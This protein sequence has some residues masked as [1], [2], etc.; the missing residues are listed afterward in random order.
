MLQL[1]DPKVYYNYTTAT[2][3]LALA[4]AMASV[5]V[6][7]PSCTGITWKNLILDNRDKSWAL[8]ILMWLQTQNL[9]AQ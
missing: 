3:G 4:M 8:Q 7:S 2:C 1:E 9:I 6:Y 5:H